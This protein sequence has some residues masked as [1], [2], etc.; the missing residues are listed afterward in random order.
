MNLHFYTKFEYA[1]KLQ[2]NEKIQVWTK[3]EA[4]K[5]D[6]HISLN[7]HYYTIERVSDNNHTF[8]VTP[9]F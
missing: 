5:T 2:Q 7:T 3:S 4:V 6:I 1:Q 9:V 8:K